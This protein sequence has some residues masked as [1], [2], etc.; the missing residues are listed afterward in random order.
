MVRFISV[1][2]F[3]EKG[4]TFRGIPSFSLLPEFPKISVPLVHSYSAR[5]QNVYRYNV[6]LCPSVV[7]A[8]VLEHNRNRSSEDELSFV[9]G[10]CVFF[11]LHDSGFQRASAL[12]YIVGKNVDAD[13][14]FP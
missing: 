1:E 13:C 4:N 2:R 3:R 8:D 7:L 5:L 9:V 10:T 6:C 12:S 14:W 11:Y